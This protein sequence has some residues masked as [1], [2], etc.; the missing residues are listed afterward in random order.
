[1]TTVAGYPSSHNDGAAP[2]FATP[3]Y[4]IVRTDGTLSLPMMI[5]F[6]VAEGGVPEI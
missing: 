4:F 3:N 6:D 2:R 1:M 5:R